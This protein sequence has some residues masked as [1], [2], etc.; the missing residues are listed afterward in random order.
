MSS[1]KADETT[2]SGVKSFDEFY[3]KTAKLDELE[4]IAE[5]K[6]AGVRV[7]EGNG[8][9]K[10]KKLSKKYDRDVYDAADG[11]IY[12]LDTRHGEFEVLNKGGK[13][14]GAIDF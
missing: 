3:K 13:H 6:D 1:A 8:W 14:Q 9:T 2:L 11:N 4:R 12:S 10:N 7:A 5:Y